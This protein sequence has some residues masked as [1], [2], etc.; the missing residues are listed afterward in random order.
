[1]AKIEKNQLKKRE[2]ATAEKLELIDP[3]LVTDMWVKVIEEH[4]DGKVVIEN[5]WPEASR[6]SDLEEEQE[7]NAAERLIGCHTCD[8]NDLGTKYKECM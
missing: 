7:G 2:K 3:R 6:E 1:M 4:T 8:N 5:R